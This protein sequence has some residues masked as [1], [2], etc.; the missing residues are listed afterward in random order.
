MF[1]VNIVPVQGVF[2][3]LACYT[4]YIIFMKFKKNKREREKFTQNLNA[5]KNQKAMKIFMPSFIIRTFILFCVIPGLIASIVVH[6]CGDQ[7]TDVSISVAAL[8]P[9]GWLLDPI[10]YIFSLKSVRE[11]ISVLDQ[12]FGIRS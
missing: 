12:Y 1:L 4:Y 7:A 2:F 3:V 8:F 11:N 5:I 9:I 10:M 6:Y